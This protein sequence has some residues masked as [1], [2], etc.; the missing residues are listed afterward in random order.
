MPVQKIERKRIQ[1]SLPLAGYNSIKVLAEHENKT[2]SRYV[3][4]LV[5]RDIIKNN[6]PLYCRA[7][8]D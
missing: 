2:V 8:I 1:I 5:E 7:D 3:Q 6:L 4:S